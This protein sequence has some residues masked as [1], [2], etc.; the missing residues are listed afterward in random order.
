[1]EA[2]DAGDTFDAGIR[3]IGLKPGQKFKARC[4]ARKVCTCFLC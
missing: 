2:M 4:I 1:M 3:I